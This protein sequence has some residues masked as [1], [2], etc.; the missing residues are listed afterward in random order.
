MGNSTIIFLVETYC[1]VSINHL[2]L[3]C[4]WFKGT[5]VINALSIQPV[6]MGQAQQHWYILG[7]EFTT[8]LLNCNLP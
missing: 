2:L 4:C 5:V 7:F 3:V 6:S 8:P 1:E